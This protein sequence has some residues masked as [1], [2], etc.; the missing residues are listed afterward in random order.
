MSTAIVIGATGLV[1]KCLV[2]QLLTDP[3]YSSVVALTRRATALHAD[4]YREHVVDFGRPETY[5]E[6]L[7][8][9]VLFSAMGTTR[10]EAGSIAAQRTVDYGYQF[11][12]AQLAARNGVKGYVLVSSSGANPSSLS[13]YLKMKGELERDVAGLGFS[14]LQILRPGPLTGQRDRPRRGEAVAEAVFG[15]FNTL[16]LLRSMRPISGDLVARAMRRAA[17]LSG[18]RRHDP[19]E[20]FSLAE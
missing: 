7:R 9:D 13:A 16:G 6:W 20:L 11:E 3:A 5:A 10:G 17:T 4:K 8:G 18:T 2:Q 19:Q 1:G 12:V 14:S 15:A